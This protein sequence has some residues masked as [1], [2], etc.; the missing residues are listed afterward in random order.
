MTNPEYEGIVK[1]LFGFYSPEYDFSQLLAANTPHPVG[2]PAQL[3]LF[4][5]IQKEFPELFK[6]EDG[7]TESSEL[8]S[9]ENKIVI[10]RHTNEYWY[11]QPGD[12]QEETVVSICEEGYC[13]PFCHSLSQ[14][15]II[16]LASLIL[17]QMPITA[18][19][20]VKEGTIKQVRNYVKNLKTFGNYPYSIFLSPDM[21]V[22]AI[23]NHDVRYMRLGAKTPD[24]LDQ[25]K[26]ES[27][28]ELRFGDEQ[29][30]PDEKHLETDSN[31]P[32]TEFLQDDDFGQLSIYGT[33][34]ITGI[35]PT[36]L[37]YKNV[38]LTISAED[39][40]TDD[41]AVLLRNLK[42]AK[43]R[44][45]S[46]TSDFDQALRIKISKEISEDAYSQSDDAPTQDDLDHLTNDLILSW[47]N[48]YA[49]ETVLSFKSPSIFKDNEII[50]QLT[51]KLKIEEIFIQ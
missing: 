11:I 31:T 10:K 25:L 35:L 47:L 43:K 24:I 21:Q 16:E 1:S 50:V 37:Q 20:K 4:Y 32:C 27:N 6:K 17:E 39:P 46:F 48:F 26:S 7:F 29:D 8:T 22:I 23:N 51:K 40:E 41:R 15:L 18:Q 49:E 33:E 5:T 28:V 9:I 30:A 44:I 13:G 45:R 42:I 19:C 14:Y 2:I 12:T 38:E 34:K 36:F 3:E